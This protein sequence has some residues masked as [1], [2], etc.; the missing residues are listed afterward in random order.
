MRTFVALDIPEEIRRRLGRFLDGIRGF[1]PDARFVRPESLHITLKFIGELDEGKVA[2]AKA[3]LA[4]IEAPSFALSFRKAGFFPGEKAPRVFWV[5]VEADERLAQL[6]EKV[7]AALAPLG[8]ARE[9]HEYRPHLTLARAGSGAPQRRP[10]DKP[11]LRFKH[12]QDKLAALPA[13]DFG[14]MTA[15]EFFLYQ[16]RLSPAGAQ[17]MKLARFPLGGQPMA[18]G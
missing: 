17:Y 7:D 4:A 12:L 13:P 3:A 18:A 6:A 15:A 9:E 11:N 5:G 16:S 8:V 1:V 2:A 14:T 10:G